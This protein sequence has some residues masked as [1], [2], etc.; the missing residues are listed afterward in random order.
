MI[1]GEAVACGWP[2]IFRDFL[3][4]FLSFEKSSQ[5]FGG[6][7]PKRVGGAWGITPRGN[8]GRAPI[9]LSQ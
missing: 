3:A 1:L 9:F 2:P 8:G 5:W 6:G 4:T 7:A